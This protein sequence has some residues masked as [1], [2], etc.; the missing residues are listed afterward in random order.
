MERKR[1]VA[2]VLVLLIAGSVAVGAL[3][4]LPNGDEMSDDDEDDGIEPTEI[5]PH[6][7]NA[8]NWWDLP[9]NFSSFSNYLDVLNHFAS[10]GIRYDYTD[11]YY[12]AAEYVMGYLE[13]RDIEAEFWGPHDS[14]VGIQRGYGSDNRAIV[15]GAHLDG[16]PSTT[17]IDQNAGGCATVM[18][19]ARILSQFRLPIDIY[20]CFFQG[21]MEFLDEQQKNRAMWGSQEVSQILLSQGVDV[22]AM[23]NF[24]EVLYHIPEVEG[25]KLDFE[26]KY[27]G[28]VGYHSTK[29]LADLLYAFMN[30]YDHETTLRVRQ[31]EQTQTDHWAFWDRG[32]PA[33]NVRS[34]VGVD[35]MLPYSDS[36]FWDFF[37]KEQGFHLARAAASVAVYL[38]MK[39]KGEH[40]SQ[41]IQTPLVTGE[42]DSLTTV[43]TVEQEFLIRGTVPENATLALTVKRGSTEY[44]PTV[45]VQAGNFS[46]NT[47]TSVGIGLVTLEVT[48]TG[49][50]ND[51]FTVFMEYSSDTNG[52]G[53]LDS[54]E[55]EWPEPD[56]PLDWDGDGLPD[57]NETRIGTDIFKVDTDGD[58]ISDYVEVQNGLNPLLHDANADYDEDGLPNHLEL[59]LGLNP[60]SNDTDDDS[61][62]DGWEVTNGLDPLVH[63]SAEDPDSD[64]LTNLEEFI[65][66][67]DPHL[68]DTDYDGIGDAEEVGRGMDPTSPDSD[69]DG[70]PDLLE[71]LEGLDPLNPDCDWDFAL[72]GSDPNPAVNR[73]LVIGIIAL[74]PVLIGS[75]ILRRRIK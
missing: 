51:T 68:A 52:N 23:Y 18:I 72:D 49:D 55:Y 16:P 47:T 59:S 38:G 71:L 24:D 13:A 8:L 42:S 70:L 34:P 74:V 73:W 9:G 33:V 40:T 66:G 5:I 53:I 28:T 64:G 67:T 29:H 43:C 39:G 58:G 17:G 50:T 7:Y 1:P 15:F 11:G 45:E 3:L 21:N 61:M 36:V 60:L 56:P 12:D 4:F 27:P 75:I 44:L 48:N 65:H 31:Y 10:I 32:F 14:V 26:Y 69:S 6:P 57:A 19:A 46:M 54:V 37:Y 2:I 20:Y 25:P 35:E 30:G 22:L 63:D 41:K 62:Q